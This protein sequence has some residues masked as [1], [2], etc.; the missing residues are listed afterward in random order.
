MKR[1]IYEYL[2]NWKNTD[3]EVPMMVVGV[4]QVGKTTT[5]EK[6]CKNE[7]NNY[8]KID[9]Y[10]NA[11]AQ[12][13]INRKGDVE[14]N[15]KDLLLYYNV[16]TDVEDTIIFFDEIQECEKLI[17]DLKI[18]NESRTKYKIICAGSLLGVKL[19]NMNYPF[20]VGKVHIIN[21]FPMN[22][23][24]FLEAIGEIQIIK[25][26]K[27]SYKN[28]KPIFPEMHQKILGIYR[29]YLCIGGMP[30]AV[31]NYIDG[32]CDLYKFN[33]SIFD[34]LNFGYM[35][36]I[37]N[38]VKDM[39]LAIKIRGVYDSIPSQLGNKSN[40]FIYSNIKNKKS[41]S[42]EYKRAISWLIQS[43]LVLKTKAIKAPE[44]PLKVMVN[45]FFKLYLHDIGILNQI[46]EIP[47]ADIILDNK[48]TYKGVITENYVAEEFINAGIPLYYWNSD[49]ESEIDFISETNTGNIIPIE[50]KAA[51]NTQSK[52]LR[53]YIDKY[54]PKYSIKLST[55]NF[56][57]ENNIK[58]IPLYATF[59]LKDD[60]GNKT[61][62]LI[63]FL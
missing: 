28:M 13:I 62:N 58:T 6:F 47:Y 53:I 56:G 7:F 42:D 41:R 46:L 17:S 10:H 32:G 40:H 55:K 39:D 22:F 63:E 61:N 48:F 12:E 15:L 44:Q 34:E 57:F 2:L 25:L 11:K 51:D 20:P 8:I 1:K 4:R 29:T 27:D 31:K 50:V 19:A 24:E 21:M 16:N 54:K 60:F 5:V 14:E 18:F 23:E 45:D 3:V 36:D 33:R 52:S 30:K 43:R 59:C 37:E 26:I 35:S 9:F 38:Y 49:N